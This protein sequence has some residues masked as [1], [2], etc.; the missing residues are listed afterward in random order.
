MKKKY[1]YALTGVAMLLLI[2]LIPTGCGSSEEKNKQEI[3]VYCGAGLKGPAEEISAAFQENTGIQVIYNFANAAQ[4]NSQILLAQKGDVYIPGDVQELE[5][6]KDKGLIEYE[7]NIVYHVP[8]LA[9]EKGN[10]KEICT[11]EDLARPGV[12]IALAD[13]KV[14]PLGKLSESLF[15]EYHILEEVSE[16]VVVGGT[17][18]S[19]LII[20]LSTQ[21]VDATIVW[22]ENY[23]GFEDK[24]ELIHLDELEDYIKT[25]PVAVLSCST[26]T[27]A[28]EKFADFM[29]SPQAG[30]VWEKWGY[31]VL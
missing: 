9:V 5:P 27:K 25:V 14:S 15:R 24:I 16:N 2:M 29:F 19:E 1:F 8:V 22:K 17:A 30:Q 28:A 3:L 7:K 4:L 13:A 10:P 31:E 26:E 21:Q 12:K 6:L 23:R 18:P 11:L 20:F